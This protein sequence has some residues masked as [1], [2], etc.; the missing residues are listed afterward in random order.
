MPTDLTFDLQ[1]PHLPQALDAGGVAQLFAGRWPAGGG[2]AEVR[3]CRLQDV[4]Y[5]PG[6]RCVATYA[7]QVERAGVL[8]QTIGVVEVTPAGLAHRLYDD[9]PRLPHLREA[10]DPTRM[11][12]RFAAVLGGAADVAVTPV[13]YRPGVRCVFRYEVGAPGGRQVLFGKLLGEGA[14]ELAATLAALHRASEDSPAL[15]RVLPALALWPEIG[16]IVQQEVAGRAELND[17]AFDPQVDAPTR[18]RWLRDAGARLAGLHGLKGVPAPARTFEDDM[19]ELREYLAPMAA[20]DPS[21]AAR[22]R[23]ALEALETRARG[24]AASAPV[25]SHGAFRTDQFLI[26]GERLVLIDLDGF[27]HADPARDLGNFL[28]YLRWKAIRRPQQEEAIA[29]AGELFLEGYAAA[30]GRSDP[31][32]LNIYRAASLLKIAGRRY[33]SLTVKEWPLVPLLV[34]NAERVSQS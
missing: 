14:S 20:A 13:R 31:A 11:A 34:D 24:R 28:A 18:E 6:Q 26:E 7:L 8:E 32:W 21:L 1:L 23:A 12:P 15:P 22:Y 27:C 25:A 19:D 2:G 30:G 33:R 9:D 3:S 29:R 10:S 16:M 5:Q 4:K 17:L